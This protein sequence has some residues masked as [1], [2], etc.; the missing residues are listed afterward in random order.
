MTGDSSA[1]SVE[2]PLPPTALTVCGGP[3]TLDADTPTAE[4]RGEAVY[5]CHAGCL[6]AFLGDP[7]RFIAGE[8]EHPDSDTA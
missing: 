2:H 8:I 6:R 4:Y 7:D 5:F 3:M 1:S